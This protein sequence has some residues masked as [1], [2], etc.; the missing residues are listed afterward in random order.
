MK[1]EATL[2]EAYEKTSKRL[3]RN[4]LPVGQGEA[5]VQNDH[6]V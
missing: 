2:C 6:P 3:A 1:S 5:K 4:D